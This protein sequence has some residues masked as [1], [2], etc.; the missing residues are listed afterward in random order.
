VTF[1]QNSPIFMAC[2]EANKRRHIRR[3]EMKT[4][5]KKCKDE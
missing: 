2:N 1:Q 3:N 5:K 4:T